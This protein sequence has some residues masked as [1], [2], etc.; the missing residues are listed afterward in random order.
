[1]DVLDL[2]LTSSGTGLSA[3]GDDVDLF[4]FGDADGPTVD[5]V[6]LSGGWTASGTMVTADITGV[7]TTFNLYV[8]GG[9]QVAVQNGLDINAV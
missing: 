7:V 2:A 4:I 1:M 6:G 3:N 5:S 9:S 8:A